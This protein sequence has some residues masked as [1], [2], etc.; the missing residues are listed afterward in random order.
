VSVQDF[1]SQDGNLELDS[2]RD[3]QPMEAG[4]RV[5]DEL[6]FD[7]VSQN[8]SG[9][10][11]WPT[12]VLLHCVLFDHNNQTITHMYISN[13]ESRQELYS[14]T[15]QVHLSVH[16]YDHNLKADINPK[17]SLKG[18]SNSKMWQILMRT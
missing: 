13:P 11:L 1:V 4:Q 5:R 14:E 16:Q 7:K 12:C 10:I 18:Q 8:T 9:T 2:L 3:A 15:C 6:T 17:V